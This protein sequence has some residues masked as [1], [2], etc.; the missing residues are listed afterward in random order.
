MESADFEVEGIHIRAIRLRHSPYMETDEETGEQFNRHE[1]VENL[2]YL[3]EIDGLTILHVGDATLN[4]N[5]ELFETG[6]FEKK[7]IDI[8]FLEYFDWTE[9]TKAVLDQWMT[10]DHVVF[11]HLPPETEKIHQIEAH[12]A[13]KFPSAVVF[14][15]PMEEKVF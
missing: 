4:E 13:Q 11:M 1:G 15:E 3:V 12:L 2:V 5:L 6:G 9:E 10:P 8:V 14:V 7:K